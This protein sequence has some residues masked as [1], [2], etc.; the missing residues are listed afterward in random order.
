MF[1]ELCPL[2][3]MSLPS[4]LCENA[5]GRLLHSDSRNV[6]AGDVFIACQGE[7]VD[8]R[9]FIPAAIA[10]GAAFVFWDDDGEFVWQDEWQVPNQ[11]IRDLKH[12]AGIV[13]A[14]VYGQTASQMKLWGVTGTNG[15]TS[16]TQWLAQAADWLD[17]PCAI[18]GTVGNGFWGK[19]Q[20]STHTTPDPVSVQTLL[21]QFQQQGAQAVAMEVSSHG[22][23]QFRVNGVPFTSA[24]FTNL[25][26]DHLDY[27]G[28]MAEYGNIKAR[29]FYWHGL[30]HAIINVD[31]EFGAQLIQRLRTERPDLAVYGYGFH[32]TADIRITAFEA[33]SQ[34]MT[35]SLNTP[36][37]KGV[38]HSRLLGRFNA[39]N[40]AACVGLLCANGY[41]F[42][43]VLAVWARIRPATGRMDCMMATGQPLV[44]VD[45]AHT[46]DALE[47]ALA[48]LQEIKP[49]GAQLWCVFGCG[50]NRDK[51]KRPLMG[52]AAVHGAD[53]VVV[54]SDNPRLEE[55]QAII[56]DILPAV[57]QPEYVHTDR[58]V[59]IEYA[60]QQAAVQDIV[61]IAGKGHETYQDIQGIKQHFSDFEVAQAALAKRGVV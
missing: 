36:W 52:A 26:R 38:V 13:A 3:E 45:Y 35:V 11:G 9:G 54:T 53:K 46:P 15:K 12:R 41:A 31:D 48:T 43:Q 51:G 23:D 8:G 22:L 44:V 1:S 25:T 40:L 60:V 28:S 59:A 56:D 37:G 55:P 27:H 16:I 17:E 19:L 34:G 47:K 4:L 39:Q 61:L 10:K 5:A 2:A 18:I 50:G 42:E 14:E 30:Q 21:H 32:P 24:I 7:Y 6:Q 57:P 29:L 58:R 20:P 33:S 49:T